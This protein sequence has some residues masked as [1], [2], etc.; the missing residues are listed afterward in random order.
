MQCL[1]DVPFE[2]FYDNA[3][4]GLEWFAAVDGTFIREYPQISFTEGRF[5]SVPILLGTNTDEGTSFGTTGTDTDEECVEQ[6]ICRTP[7]PFHFAEKSDSNSV[8]TMGARS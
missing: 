2:T 4:E 6:L 5:A 7:L 8:Q 1:R 3:F